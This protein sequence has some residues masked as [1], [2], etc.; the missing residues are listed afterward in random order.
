[1]NDTS[2]NLYVGLE[3]EIKSM[4]L[5]KRY[6]ML[7]AL[8]NGAF[9]TVY[10]ARPSFFPANNSIISDVVALKIMVIDKIAQR[11][12][13]HRHRR[14]QDNGKDSV[15]PCT[16]SNNYKEEQDDDDD[17][18]D[19]TNE[20]FFPSRFQKDTLFNSCSK[21]RTYKRSADIV[22][23]Q[24][25]VKRE[26]QVHQIASQKTHPN[27]VRLIESFYY[28]SPEKNSVCAIA[29]EYCNLGDLQNYMKKIKEVRKTSSDNSL[30]VWNNTFLHENETRHVVIHVLRGLAY[31]HSLGIAHRDIKP[32]NIFISP[33]KHQYYDGVE[34]RKKN[35][36]MFSLLDCVLKIGDFGLAVKMSDE[37]DWDE[38]NH[39][40]CGTPSCL[41]PEVALF[42]Y[43]KGRM[44][45]A[46][47]QKHEFTDEHTLHDAVS[48][49]KEGYGQPA[50][51]W[52]TGC[53][54]YAMLC[55]RYPFSSQVQKC[56]GETNKE[57]RIT[58]TIKRV[59][60][61]HWSIPGEI[62]IS[63]QAKS[64][65]DCLLS[66][67]PKRR[68]FAR[69]LLSNQPFLSSSS[70]QLPYTMHNSCG[71]NKPLATH[72]EQNSR[73]TL[74][75]AQACSIASVHHLRKHSYKSRT[76][77]KGNDIDNHL[78]ETITGL[79]YI[80]PGRYTWEE[81]TKSGI[82]LFLEMFVLP[83][84]LGVVIQCQR[85]SNRRSMTG[86]WMHL[87]RSGSHV[88]VGKLAMKG[89]PRSYAW[90][91]HSNLASDPS[92]VRLINNAFAR[93][94]RKYTCHPI[95]VDQS[96]VGYDQPWSTTKSCSVNSSSLQSTM[97]SIPSSIADSQQTFTESAYTTKKLYKPLATLLTKKYD[98]C[99]V[100]YRLATKYLNTISRLHSCLCMHIHVCSAE[101]I[102]NN[103]KGSHVCSVTTASINSSKYFI[104]N[105]K[106][107]LEIRYSPS[108]ESGELRILGDTRTEKLHFD[109]KSQSLALAYTQKS[110]IY[111]FHLRF[112]YEAIKKCL[113]YFESN[114]RLARKM[115]IIV[116]A[117]GSSSK[118]WHI[119]S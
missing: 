24:N 38:A 50:D 17:S 60:T 43:S 85:M 45:D 69:G 54:M 23:I 94:P 5:L 104:L 42:G 88:C 106:D 79:P 80:F 101:D 31:I 41:A 77:L 98:S 87:A 102:G 90:M 116:K 76:N 64:L 99:L 57:D 11:R 35:G 34:R 100:I 81:M 7:E 44:S 37:D 36:N 108:I 40:L 91:P 1:M 61:G 2:A 118:E 27:I 72:F 67:N 107:S 105:F 16:L 62:K 83:K 117:K 68:G 52:S 12:H 59:I 8:G 74:E 93:R 48:G 19:D 22:E 112:A 33:D 63:I 55:G 111:S 70:C 30:F 96:N 20:L 29:M 82:K 89:L 66:T 78:L 51:L 4:D 119:V 47:C 18:D 9:A 26:I 95:V 113:N 86:I 92:L 75:G 25:M 46:I 65:L 71:N 39:T 10:K 110:Q 56:N 97:C 15:I 21:S 58:E 109:L 28:I 14:Y 114:F 3:E 32:G 6:Q 53:L 115:P 49:M 103:E 73:H 84:L 13:R